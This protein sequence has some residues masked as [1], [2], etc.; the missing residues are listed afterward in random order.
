MHLGRYYMYMNVALWL[1]LPSAGAYAFVFRYWTLAKHRNVS[2][3]FLR[4]LGIALVIEAGFAAAVIG[5]LYLVRSLV[6][7]EAL[8]ALWLS[9]VS[10]AALQ[11]IVPVPASERRRV[12][13]GVLAFAMTP[14]RYLALAIGA[15]SGF[16]SASH[17]L[18]VHALYCALLAA[19]AWWIVRRNVDP[20]HTQ[21]IKSVLPRGTGRE[22]LHFSV[23][24]IITA[25]LTQLSAS[26]ER[27][28]LAGLDSPAAAAVFVLSVGVATAGT[29][30]VASPLLAYYQPLITRAASG[31]GGASATAYLR[32]LVI[33]T[34]VVVVLVAM[35]AGLFSRI[36]TAYLFGREYAII[37]DVL[38]WTAIG[39]GAF[40]IGQALSMYP[41]AA[42][43][44]L[45]PNVAF[46]AAQI[47]YVV[48]LLTYRPTQGHALR[49]ARVY[50][51]SYSGYA[52]LMAA[53]AWR[54]LR[55]L[56]FE[57]RQEA[58][59]TVVAPEVQMIGIARPGEGP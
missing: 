28:G 7:R 14:L 56:T 51:A 35:G 18:W 23:P 41:Y 39:A 50:A 9:G 43:D 15:R 29:N 17:L 37:A 27:W 58:V 46:G 4:L 34:F 5:G 32:K 3:T 54:S 48:I 12:T 26:A 22:V 25:C 16:A 44:G 57:R 2:M 45:R 11:T 31:I 13:A 53:I 38:P 19:G 24:Y 21:P 40:A 30:A 55:S 49:F 1:S 20:R 59:A 52:A 6:A 10:Q 33:W 8:V 42:K 36:A 47:V